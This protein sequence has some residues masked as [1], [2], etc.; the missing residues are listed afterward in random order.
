MAQLTLDELVAL[1]LSRRDVL[2][3]GGA[4]GFTGL[5]GIPQSA[6]TAIGNARRAAPVLGFKSVPI[7]NA[8][9]VAMPESYTSR[10]FFSCGDPILD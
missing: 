10:I 3:L 7:S 5:L 8:D 9:T 6:C 4:T 1:R 2:K